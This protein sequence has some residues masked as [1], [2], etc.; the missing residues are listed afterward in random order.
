M[1]KPID[2]EDLMEQVYSH[3]DYVTGFAFSVDDIIFDRVLDPNNF[4][5]S[6]YD[7]IKYLVNKHRERINKNVTAYITKAYMNG[8]IFREIDN[9]NNFM[10]LG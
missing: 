5:Q 1:K 4:T 10:D 9:I 6:E 8:D 3:P 7:E 2:F